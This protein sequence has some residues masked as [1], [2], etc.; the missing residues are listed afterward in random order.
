MASI[1]RVRPW[2]A[3]QALE[4]GSQKSDDMLK[5]PSKPKFKKGGFEGK[6][7]G[8]YRG[9]SLRGGYHRVFREPL[10]GA[11]NMRPI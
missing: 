11:G 2:Y 5:T 3:K 8:G 9:F 7:G 10:N 6:R 4:G 1:G